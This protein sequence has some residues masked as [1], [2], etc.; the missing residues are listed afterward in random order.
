MTPKVLVLT[1]SFLPKVGGI[2]YKL[3]WFLDNLDRRLSDRR[4]LLV[5]FAY[6]N[7]R[8]AP[9]ARFANIS[10]F[11]LQLADARRTSARML[12]RL[13]GFLRR[14]Q[15]DVIDCRSLMPDAL[16]ALLA[17]RVYAGRA[18]VVATS[19]GGDIVWMPQWSFGR[20]RR[21]RSRIVMTEV[22]R[23]ISAHVVPSRAML[24]F[25]AA[26][27]TPAGRT[28]VIPSGVP[29][30][31][32]YDFED[33]IPIPRGDVIGRRNGEGLDILCLSSGRRVKNLEALVEAFAL[34][35]PR[36]GASRLILG[37]H[38]PT[39]EP[40]VRL[41]GD[42]S[43]DR[44]VVFVGEVAGQ[45]K[46]AWFRMADV[47]CLPSHFESF[48][49]VVLEA[50]KSGAAVLAGRVGGILDF[51]TDGENGLLVSP[52]DRETIAAALVRLYTDPTLRS[53]LIE[54]GRQTAERYS[55]S[56]NVDAMLAL[57]HRVA[58]GDG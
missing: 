2:Q 12:V 10:T 27:G 42:R 58:R 36:L 28:L 26:S 48:G 29:I 38:G 14:T 45:T 54:N 30:G 43:L 23:R 49:L 35:R 56:R 5:S 16:W 44:N 6:P 21:G 51:V 7:A 13:G 37:C 20:S 52:P 32:D 53:R 40:I 33:D 9:Y 4:D 31:N 50:M 8:S 17:S 15:P 57:Y 25:A 46:R 19:E 18:R 47:Y 3:K 55:I 41:V 11:D 24:E 39:A 34:A 22:T 1:S